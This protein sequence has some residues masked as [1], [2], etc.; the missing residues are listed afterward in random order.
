MK[1]WIVD[2]NENGYIRVHSSNL[3][4][5]SLI[6]RGIRDNNEFE[7]FLNSNI[8]DLYNPYLL[9]DMG[10]AV[11]KIDDVIRKREKI[12]IYGNYD[13][14]G[15]TSTSILYRALRKLGAH[16]SYY[17]PDRLNEGYGINKDA[18]DYI[19][20]LATKLI[21]TVDCGISSVNEVEYVKS[22]GMDIIITDHQ[23]CKESIPDTI[24]IN[25][26][27]Y[28]CKYPYK[29]LVG[30]GVAFKLV[31]ALWIRYNLYGF[32][33]FLDIT[34]IGIISDIVN[35]SGENGVIVKNGLKRILTSEKCGIKA[36][37]AIAGVVE[38]SSSTC[39]AF[40]IAPKVSAIGRLKD[41]KIAVELFTTNDYDKALQI[42]KYLDRENRNIQ[43]LEQHIFSEA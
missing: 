36:I 41:A 17:I 23:E 14:D 4:K 37:K 2:S 7:K 35:L 9:K 6:S 42:A 15:V 43:K 20:S 25:P 21:I 33:D 40:Q 8:N 18:V 27:R 12:V 22:L 32:E 13:V 3:I 11:E 39:I 30:C 34:A 19:K 29:E 16:V 10:K 1:R 28:D 26:K 24:V 31:H 38:E 5:K